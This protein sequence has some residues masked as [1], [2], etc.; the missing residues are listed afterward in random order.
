MSQLETY[1]AGVQQLKA[2]GTHWIKHELEAMTEVTA[3]SGLYLQ[4]L[5][6]VIAITSNLQHHSTLQGKVI[7]R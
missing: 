1:S 3:Q 6:N 4:H 2:T 5:Q 7:T